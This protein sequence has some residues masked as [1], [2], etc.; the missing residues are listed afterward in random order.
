M[1][2]ADTLRDAWTSW[3]LEPGIGFPAAVRRDRAEPRLISNVISPGPCTAIPESRIFQDRTP[4]P[5][6]P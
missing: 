2:D 4:V 6:E 3:R 1:I 5:G